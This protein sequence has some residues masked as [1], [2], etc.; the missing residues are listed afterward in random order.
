MLLKKLTF[1][2]KKYFLLFRY[3][4][5]KFTLNIIKY[6]LRTRLNLLKKILPL[7]NQDS[8]IYK[9]YLDHLFNSPNTSSTE[10]IEYKEYYI[11]NSR[12]DVKII[13][14]YLPQFH[15]IPE[16]DTWWGKGFTEW[17]NV[18][19]AFPQFPGHYQPHLPGELGFYD[20]RNTAIMTRQI[21]LAKNYGIYGFCFYYYWFSGRRI[22]DM[23]LNSFFNDPDKDF[24]F[25]ICWANESWTRRWDGKDHDILLEQNYNSENDIE[26]IRSI[27]PFLKDPRYIRIE[28]KPLIIVYRPSLLPEPKKTSDTWRNYCRDAG[29]GDIYLCFTTSFD[30]LPP[31]AFKFDCVI[32]FP[33]N[34]TQLKDISKSLDIVNR[35]FS[36][37]IFNYEEL[38][39]IYAH[40]ALPGYDLFKGITPSWDNTARKLNN[41]TILWNSSPELFK[42]WFNKIYNDTINQN[43]PSKRF[44]FI[45]AWNEWAE[46]AHLEPDRKYGYAYLDAIAQVIKNNTSQ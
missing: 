34:N 37:K 8:N 22:L 3:Q 25:C 31:D 17:I 27:I 42:Q 28:D 20:L 36:G 12:D 10:H 15:P 2:R 4:G 14:F 33:P 18:T 11:S 6:E 43:A 35:S 44:I 45:N 38:L 7:Q 46:G 9:Q 29:I 19:R 21:E 5:I 24:P 39:K 13:P 26:F 1:W 41:G 30:N 40:K 16:N 32:E 23:P